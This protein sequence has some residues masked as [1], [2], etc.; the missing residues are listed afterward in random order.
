CVLI[1]HIF[2]HANVEADE[3]GLEDSIINDNVSRLLDQSISTEVFLTSSDV[4]SLGS[5]HK[6]GQDSLGQARG[7][8]DCQ[9]RQGEN[10]LQISGKQ[11]CDVVWICGILNVAAS[12]WWPPM[13]LSSMSSFIQMRKLVSWDWKTVLSMTV[14]GISIAGPGTSTEPGLR[15]Q[16]RAR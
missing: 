14:L 3:L 16:A 5:G 9:T 1:Q 11:F 2:I 13:F 8:L 6:P 7:N 10:S 15:P 4:P 12:V